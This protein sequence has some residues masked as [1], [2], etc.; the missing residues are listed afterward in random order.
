MYK[1]RY[2]RLI[3]GCICAV[4]SLVVGITIYTNYYNN[5]YKNY[6]RHSE[7]ERYYSPDKKHYIMISVMK[8]MT[9]GEGYY[10]RANL[11]RVEYNEQNIEI[12]T[13]NNVY[14]GVYFER[15]TGSAD[16]NI[17]DLVEVK[18]IDNNNYQIDG[19]TYSVEFFEE[20][21]SIR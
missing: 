15:K 11:V 17:G 1:K 20:N 2:K 7:T 14:G 18:W 3:I 16:G 5:K 10:L 12:M 6:Y 9:Y 21:R 4:L 19:E 13:T 8:P